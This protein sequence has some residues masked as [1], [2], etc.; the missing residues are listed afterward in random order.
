MATVWFTQ[1]LAGISDIIMD[2]SVFKS[3]TEY[4]FD[5]GS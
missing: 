5:N 1:A 3:K 4:V 2:A